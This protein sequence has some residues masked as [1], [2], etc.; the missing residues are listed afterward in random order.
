[1]PFV[2]NCTC[3]AEVVVDTRQADER[4]EN[5]EYVCYECGDEGQASSRC[6]GKEIT[7]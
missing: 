4:F 1:M 6:I 7:R 2:F 3:E 5:E